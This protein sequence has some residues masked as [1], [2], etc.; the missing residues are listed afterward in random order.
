M[1]GTAL[2]VPFSPIVHFFSGRSKS[3]VQCGSE[4]HRLTSEDEARLATGFSRESREPN[5]GV[6]VSRR[7][8]GCVRIGFDLAR[9]DVK[10]Q[11]SAIERLERRW[12][13]EAASFS[14]PLFRSVQRRVHF[15]RSFAQFEVSP[16]HVEGWKLELE[17]ILSDPNSYESI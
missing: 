15:A 13:E 3:F 7:P 8:N 16:E 12:H 5:M 10:L 17:S 6:Y 2:L 11:P 4:W 9:L 1:S 14:K